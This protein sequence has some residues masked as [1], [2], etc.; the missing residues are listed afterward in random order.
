MGTTEARFKE[1]RYYIPTTENI[2]RPRPLGPAIARFCTEALALIN[3]DAGLVQEVIVLLASEGGCRRIHEIVTQDFEMLSAAQL[4]RVFD[5]QLLP[6]LQVITHK[7][8]LDSMI[9]GSRLMTI[10]NIV[11]GGGGQRASTLFAVLAQHL[12]TLDPTTPEDPGAPNEHAVLA[13][14]TVF[15]ALDKL[16]EVNTEAQVHD[17]LKLVVE[18]LE[19]LF[20]DALPP[21]AAFSYSTLR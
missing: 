15:T 3:G 9:L 18:T 20:E 2:G 21:S 10:Y 11:Y 1:W 17:G 16:I 4:A 7:S 6:F 12:Q 14:D 13:V 5:A 8:V 19:T